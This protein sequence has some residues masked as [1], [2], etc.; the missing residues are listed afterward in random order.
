MTSRRQ[1]GA[2]VLLVHLCIYLT[3]TQGQRKGERQLFIQQKV[4]WLE[5]TES[6]F[7]TFQWRLSSFK[8][9][10][11]RATCQGNAFLEIHFALEVKETQR[12]HGPLDRKMPRL[13]KRLRDFC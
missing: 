1:W 13:T 2:A 6:F 7:L 8:P 12:L 9:V 5:F 3:A 11:P 4:F 10:D